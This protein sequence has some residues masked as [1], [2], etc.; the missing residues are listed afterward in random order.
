MA[1][2][3]IIGWRLQR[4]HWS[5][6]SKVKENE[7]MTAALHGYPEI[8]HTAQREAMIRSLVKMLDRTFAS[9]GHEEAL[10]RFARY[11]GTLDDQTLSNLSYR[12]LFCDSEP[13]LQ[14]SGPDTSPSVDPEC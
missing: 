10:D 9:L 14:E 8:K 6:T 13:C 12:E 11:F 4:V 5:A 3:Q 1:L 7:A 2:A